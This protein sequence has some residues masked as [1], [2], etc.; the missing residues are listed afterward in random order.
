MERE[1]RGTRA[2]LA[3]IKNICCQQHYRPQ[4]GF[5][6]NIPLF[7]NLSLKRQSLDQGLML[8]DQSQVTWISPGCR[9]IRGII[10]PQGYPPK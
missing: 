2:A 6:P 7:L 5:N 10:C 3:R 9:G 8:T 4:L 1:T